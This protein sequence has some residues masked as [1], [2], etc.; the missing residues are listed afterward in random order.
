MCRTALGGVIVFGLVAC[1]HALHVPDL[2]ERHHVEVRQSEFEQETTLVGLNDMFA[3]LE[4]LSQ[5]GIMRA[6]K[7]EYFLRSWVDPDEQSVR[8]QI[9]VDIQYHREEWDHWRNANSEEAEELEVT[10]INTDVSRCSATTNRCTYNEIIGIGVEHEKLTRFEETGLRIRL[11][12]R[13]GR[14]QDF[15]L[16]SEQIQAQLD[17][18]RTIL[19][20]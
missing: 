8:H 5:V 9:Y 10:R 19:G 2:E 16:S 12:A 11:Y 17:E 1:A 14:E 13:S 3:D 6:P 20:G 15:V 7:G 4:G 18:V